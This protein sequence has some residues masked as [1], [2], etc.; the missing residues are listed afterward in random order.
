[1]NGVYHKMSGHEHGD[2]LQILSN[3][4]GG[5][6]YAR[7]VPSINLP[8]DQLRGDNTGNLSLSQESYI[9]LAHLV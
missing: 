6:V 7:V 9:G 2:F 4:L 1:M 8:E 3:T 5:C